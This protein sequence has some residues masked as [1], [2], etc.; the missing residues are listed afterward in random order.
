MCARIDYGSRGPLAKSGNGTDGSRNRW[1]NLARQAV[2][3]TRS[4]GR[5]RT[6]VGCTHFVSP[7]SCNSD[8]VDPIADASSV[9]AADADVG[10]CLDSDEC[11]AVRPTD[12]YASPKGIGRWASLVARNLMDERDRDMPAPP[13]V[14]LSPLLYRKRDLRKKIGSASEM[15]WPRDSQPLA[16]TSLR[17]FTHGRRTDGIDRGKET[18]LSPLD[19]VT[20]LHKRVS[21]GVL[22]IERLGR[23]MISAIQLYVSIS[24]SSFLHCR[25]WAGAR[26]GAKTNGRRSPRWRRR[27]EGSE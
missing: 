13:L 9:Q 26:A 27:Q 21:V 25:T 17:H 18:R 23:G 11:A 12:R 3:P 16:P 6:D 20:N 2:K 8:A 4:I 1:L 15:I 10:L 7:T 5:T 14:S 22:Y 24:F 19:A